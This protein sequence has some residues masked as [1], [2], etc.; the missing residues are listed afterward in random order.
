MQHQA[1]AQREPRT[2]RHNLVSVGHG[3]ILSCAPGRVLGQALAELACGI[4]IKSVS[5]INGIDLIHVFPPLRTIGGTGAANWMS[6]VVSSP[7]SEVR[8]LA[9]YHEKD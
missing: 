8:G 2:L 5:V 7:A 3:G 4:G 6:A 1:V 9:A